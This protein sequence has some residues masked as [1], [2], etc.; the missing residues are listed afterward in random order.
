M[1]VS[2]ATTNPNITLKHPAKV[3]S[4]AFSQEVIHKSMGNV[5]FI[6]NNLTSNCQLG[7]YGNFVA[8]LGLADKDVK[9]VLQATWSSASGKKINVNRCKSKK[10]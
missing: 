4:S 9:E 8:L 7:C 5:G 6:I 2:K 10:Y 1:L 3:E